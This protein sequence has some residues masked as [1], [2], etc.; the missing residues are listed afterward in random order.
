M[1]LIETLVA[2]AVLGIG[3][4]GAVQLAVQ[5]LQTATDTRQRITAHGLALD[6]M[7][8]HQSGRTGCPMNDQVT[9]QTPYT[10]TVSLVPRPGLALMDLTVTVQ[11]SGA[12][13]S[14]AT[15]DT[16][17]LVLRSSR[18][19]VPLWVGVSLP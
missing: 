5:S 16:P 1:A 7:E 4:A 10:R 9:L 18:A 6:L 17:Q 8:C 15:G 19:T 2:S 14:G 11:W 12:A 13:R 3:M